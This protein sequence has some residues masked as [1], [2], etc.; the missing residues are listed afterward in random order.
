MIY[1]ATFSTAVLYAEP[2]VHTVWLGPPSSPPPLLVSV[3]ALSTHVSAPQICL[4][5]TALLAVRLFCKL[6]VT[7]CFVFFCCFFTSSPETQTYKKKVFIFLW[8]I[9]DKTVENSS[10]TSETGYLLPM[11]E[12]HCSRSVSLRCM[13]FFVRF[14]RREELSNS[15]L[16]N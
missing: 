8:D 3:N 9:M 6:H 10:H 14:I 15:F 4:V 5:F 1:P 7:K 12:K 13:R 16:D 11:F 2:C